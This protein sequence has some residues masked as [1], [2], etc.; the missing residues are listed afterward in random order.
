MKITKRHLR[1]IIRE[2]TS[3]LHEAKAKVPKNIQKIVMKAADGFEEG[4]AVIEFRVHPN[5]GAW[6]IE[7][8]TEDPDY[9]VPDFVSY[10][11]D[12]ETLSNH[13]I[14]YDD[15]LIA[16]EPLS[17]DDDDDDDGW[18]DDPEW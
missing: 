11:S 4:F 1:R 2:E 7:T 15:W 3:R 14:N 17:D 6:L 9:V 5:T 16:I 10:L 12:N 8:D 13:E 18:D